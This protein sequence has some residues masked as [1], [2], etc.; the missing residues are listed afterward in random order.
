MAGKAVGPQ[1]PQLSNALAAALQH[2]SPLPLALPLPPWRQEFDVVH[3]VVALHRI[4]KST[5]YRELRQSAQL[6]QQLAMLA[7]NASEAV[8]RL[9]DSTMVDAG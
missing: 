6:R 4:A 2:K 7:A 5:D 9:Q 1:V 8:P 3:L